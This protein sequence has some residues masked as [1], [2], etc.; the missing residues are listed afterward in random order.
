MDPC[1]FKATLNYTNSMQ[2]QIQVVLA[3]TF[4][5]VPGSHAFNPSTRGNI[6][7]EEREALVWLVC[8]NPALVE[9]SLL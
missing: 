5:P 7:W 8:G 4:I 3:Y 1:E 9:I 2:K 6:K